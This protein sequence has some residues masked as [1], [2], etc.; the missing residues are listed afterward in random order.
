V[1]RQQL[2]NPAGVARADEL[3]G[4]VKRF[5]IRALT[6]V[7]TLPHD[8]ATLAV[9]RQLARSAPGVS[10]NYHS[11]GRSRSS[12]EFRARLGVVLDEAD[13]TVGWLE[14]LKTSGSAAGP[15]I[16]W[17]L[18]ESRELRAIFVQAVK[19]ARLNAQRSQ[20]NDRDQTS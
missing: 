4:R 11:A 16:D 15:E 17:L 2:C 5:A 1:C 6:F 14:M 10:A 20:R 3:R 7:K 19:T 8:P 12:A 13:E 18:R 9:A